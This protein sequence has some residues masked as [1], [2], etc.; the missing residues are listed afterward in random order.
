MN[1]FDLLLSKNEFTT[2]NGVFSKYSS[3]LEPIPIIK[4]FK[5]FSSDEFLKIKESQKNRDNYI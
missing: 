1:S 4:V 3:F 2:I 5:I